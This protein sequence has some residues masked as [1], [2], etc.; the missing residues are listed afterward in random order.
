MDLGR[1]HGNAP[2]CQPGLEV[3]DGDANFWEVAFGAVEGP[4]RLRAE[5]LVD[6]DLRT[7]VVP[8]PFPPWFDESGDGDWLP[9]QAVFFGSSMFNMG[10]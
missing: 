4:P 8:L 2:P 1:K 5:Q 7:L 10:G 9:N 3:A 6:V